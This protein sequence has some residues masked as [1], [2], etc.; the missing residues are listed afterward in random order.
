MK[1]KVHVIAPRYSFGP[2]HNARVGLLHNDKRIEVTPV[3]VSKGHLCVFVDATHPV[4]EG[5]RFENTR[6]EVQ[7]K[8]YLLKKLVVYRVGSVENSTDQRVVLR[9]DEDDNTSTILWELSYLLR[10]RPSV[11]A[12]VEYDD[13]SLPKVPGRGLYT[14]EARQE[15]LAFVRKETGAKLEY[16]AK[17][18]FDPKALVSNIEA[19][20]GSVEIPVGVGGPLY[21][22]G[23]HANGL[24]Y[25][26]MATSE[27]ALVASVTRGA[28]AITR[29]GGATT[30]VI[31]Q[32]MMRVPMFILSDMSSALFFAEWVQDHYKEIAAQTRRYSNYANLQE[33]QAQVFGKTVYVH[34]IYMTGDAAGQNMTTTCTWQACQWIIGEVKKFEGIQF[35]SFFIESN[36]SND[37]KVTYQSFIKGRGVRVITECVLTREVCEQILKVPPDQMYRGYNK[38]LTGCISAGMI[39]A[40]IN[41]AN[42]IGAMFTACGQD[43]ACVHES[44]IGQLYMDLLDDDHLYCAMVLPSLVVGTVGGGTGLPHQRELLEMIGCAGP[45]CSHKLAEIICS[46]CLALDLSTMAAIASDQFAR[47]HEKLG[48]NRPVNWLKLG[49]FD[50]AFFDR[51]FRHFTGD[52]STKVAKA[53]YRKVDNLG[54]SII[55]ELTSH[56]ISKLVGHFPFR[57]ELEGQADPVDVMIKIKPLDSEVILVSNSM[58]AMCDARLAQSYNKFKEKL[59]FRGCHNRELRVMSQTDERFR[60]HAPITYFTVED[61]DR[62]AYV[63]VQEYMTGLELMD[64]ADDVR[65]WTP[66]HIRAAVEGIAEVHSIWFDKP[67]EAGAQDFNLLT[68]NRVSM[69]QKIRLWEMLGAHATQEFPE[70]FRDI[71]M[72]NFR[73]RVYTIVDWYGKI[74]ALPHTVIHNDFNPRNIGFRRTDAGLNL[75]AY[76][77]ELASWHLPQHDVAELL[78]F[79]LN[80]RSTQEEVDEYLEYHRLAME[81]HTGRSLDRDQWYYGYHLSLNDLLINRI[82]MY[83]MG[84]TFRHY[85][86]MERIVKTFRHLLV[87]DTV[88]RSAR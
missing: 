69:M 33:V 4:L 17:T 71:D 88:R 29:A 55:T 21:I 38:A 3:D 65:G 47:A 66:E 83:V 13:A 62:E 18:T 79:V 60:K 86:F 43:I 80:E 23:E 2:E 85:K 50:A 59:E 76:D 58:A 74:D 11:S 34:F 48:R 39:G 32:R 24:F 10:T 20:M 56:K 42:V 82:P 12:N 51:A 61:P 44:A 35:E 67:K 9:A 49:D 45:G 19:F 26:P 27:G 68:P 41:I 36:L 78:T 7:E 8:H 77:W 70:W 25:A 31:G 37:K 84:H 52:A 72:E 5:D 54:S 6:V 63:L 87:L 73:Q 75:I 40:N 57:V 81:K 22:K 46:F 64:S 53:E 16:V 14:E 1:Q 15:R 28:T 30:R